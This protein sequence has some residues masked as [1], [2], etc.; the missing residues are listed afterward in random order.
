MWQTGHNLN[1][2]GRLDY[3]LNEVYNQDNIT[4]D[5]ALVLI[6]QFLNAAHSYYEYKSNSLIGDTG[7]IIVLGGLNDKNDYFANDLTY[8]FLKAV[9]DLNQPGPKLILRY[10]KETPEDLMNLALETMATGVGSPL[11]SNDE[12]VIPNLINFGYN[13]QDAYNYVVSACWEPAPVGKK[14][15][16]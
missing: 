12:M 9:K 6:K 10:S 5:G 16:I 15:Y 2:L 3:V 7:Q 13:A 8:L 11:I 4:K 14:Y 1:G